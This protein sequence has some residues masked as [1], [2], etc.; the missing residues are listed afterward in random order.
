MPCHKN[1]SQY[2][3]TR[4]NCYQVPIDIISYYYY[5]IVV[6]E[7]WCTCTPLLPIGT[8]LFYGSLYLLPLSLCKKISR[9]CKHKN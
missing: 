6:L 4:K 7:V 3:Y 5:F 9:I 8:Y 2:I 1:Y